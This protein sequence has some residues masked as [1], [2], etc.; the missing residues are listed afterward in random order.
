[1][2]RPWMQPRRANL[3]KSGGADWGHSGA[4]GAVAPWGAVFGP[5]E[6]ILCQGQHP[7]LPR[8]PWQGKPHLSL[9]SLSSSC[10][11]GAAAAQQG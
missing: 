3:A 1:M 10:S 11:G 4:G 5:A 7:H 2:E 9:P 8:C 6:G